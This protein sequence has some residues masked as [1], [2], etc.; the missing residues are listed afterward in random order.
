[1]MKNVR[2]AAPQCINTLKCPLFSIS[3]LQC[4][5]Q[6]NVLLLFNTAVGAYFTITNKT[7]YYIR[8]VHVFVI[9]IIIS[10][11]I[12]HFHIDTELY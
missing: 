5:I 7:K 2:F 4:V 10:I 12:N 9:L 8:L 3:L 11:I 6:D 1:M